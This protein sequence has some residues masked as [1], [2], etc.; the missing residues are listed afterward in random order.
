[1]IKLLDVSV[2]LPYTVFTCLGVLPK[3]GG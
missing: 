3:N 1:M 2:L